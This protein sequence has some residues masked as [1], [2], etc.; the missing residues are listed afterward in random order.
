M[1]KK[2]AIGVGTTDKCN[3]NCPHCYSRRNQTV[4]ITYEEYKALLD[5]VDVTSLNFGTGENGLNPDFE[6]ILDLT[7]ERGIPC[8]LTSNGYTILKL[9]EERL[10]RLNDLDVSLEFPTEEKQ[11]AFRGKDSWTNA[12]NALEYC[13]K[14]GITVSIAMCLMNINYKD[15]V[16]FKELMQK[17]NVYLR[18]NIYKPVN[19][20]KFSLSYEEFWDA[21]SMIFREFRVMSCSEP[22]INAVLGIKKSAD[23][24]ECGCGKTSLRI[25]PYGHV[26]PCVYWKESEYTINDFDKIDENT[27]KEIDL[28]PEAC[29]DCEYVRTCRGGCAGRRHYTGI[30]EPDIY[31]PFLRGDEIKLDYRPEDAAENSSEEFV[32]A[33][34]L[35]TMILGLR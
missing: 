12:I 7:Y 9:S 33:S 8:S 27:F 28:I 6:R 16:Q 26:V 30:T 3:L 4:T 35:C 20:D 2:W 23:E 15:I 1:S 29:K 25:T 22:I 21:V 17:Y 11:S 19:T 32:H 10:K 14:L 18:V 5:K 31:C 34:Y 13:Q 24:A